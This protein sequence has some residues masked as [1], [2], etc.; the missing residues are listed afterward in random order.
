[1]LSGSSPTGS[2][3]KVLGFSRAL[4]ASR[5]GAEPAGRD[6]RI[7]PGADY[8]LTRGGLVGHPDVARPGDDADPAACDTIRP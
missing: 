1:M 6:C 5:V 2:G 8:T 4:I 7:G 3:W